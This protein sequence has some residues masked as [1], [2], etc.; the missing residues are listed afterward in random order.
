[1]K[2]WTFG[3]P[4][5]FVFFKKV[6]SYSTQHS[7]TF[8]HADDQ[9]RISGIPITSDTCHFFVL[10]NILHSP[11]AHLLAVNHSYPSVLWAIKLFLLPVPY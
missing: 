8:V 2:S 11:S 10:G 3:Q 4:L 9:V 5:I 7:S 6:L 1:M